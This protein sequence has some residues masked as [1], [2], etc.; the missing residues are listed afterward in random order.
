MND[1]PSEQNLF[2][3]THVFFCVN[4]REKGHRRGCCLAKDSQT[5]RD[6]MKVKAKEMK[7]PRVRINSSGCLDRCELGPSVVIYPEGVWYT[8]KTTEDVDRILEEHLRDGGR[9]DDLLMP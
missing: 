7:L 3:T 9:V 6:Y 1:T 8:C 2:F 5:L 4:E